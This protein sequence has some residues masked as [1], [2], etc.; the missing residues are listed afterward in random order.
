MIFNPSRSKSA[1]TA[2]SEISNKSRKTLQR[3]LS[4]LNALV[5]KVVYKLKGAA[6]FYETS[7]IIDGAAMKCKKLLKI[8][9]TN[10]YM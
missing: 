3:R 2:P 10:F 6:A 1:V 4:T 9:Y 5:L 8:I 7:E